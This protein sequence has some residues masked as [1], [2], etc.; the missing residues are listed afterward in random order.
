MAKTAVDCWKTQGVNKTQ[1]FWAQTMRCN[2]LVP[3]S[4]FHFSSKI[5]IKS[6]W[7]LKQPNFSSQ[8]CRPPR[9]RSI[10]LVSETQ[11][12]PIFLDR[13]LRL[14][15][16]E[17]LVLLFVSAWRLT[18]GK[19]KEPL[20]EGIQNLRKTLVFVE[21]TIIRTYQNHNMT[22]ISQET[23]IT[24]DLLLD[25][26]PSVSWPQKIRGSTGNDCHNSGRPGT[27]IS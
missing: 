13:L 6:T 7:Y 8:F 23:T 24:K 26:G 19:K 16:T 20:L 14:I 11:F 22:F 18:L 1:A 21:T 12:R 2:T 15:S 17:S 5:V 3:I 4:H 10:L 27:V 25:I 9:L